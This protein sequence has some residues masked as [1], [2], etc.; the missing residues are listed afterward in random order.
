MLR[1]V[2]LVLFTLPLAGC[3]YL[4]AAKGQLELTR[5]REPI[6]DILQDEDTSPELAARLRLVQEA[7][8]FSIEVLG[9][10]DNDSYRTF[11]DIE[12]DY[13]VWNVFA[14]PEFSMQPKT[15]CFPVAGCVGYR[16]YF[17]EAA[18]RRE[19]E[20]LKAKGFDVVVGGVAAYSTLGKLKDPVVS[21]MMRWDDLQLVA[22]L[23]HELAHQ[24]LYVKGDSGFNESFATAVEEFG[25]HQWL[26]ARGAERDIERYESSRLLRQD[27]ME[28]VADARADLQDLYTST[29]SADEMRLQKGVRLDALANNVVALLESEGRETKGWQAA[30]LN[31]ARLASMALYEGRVP[32]FRA[33]LERCD[34]QID[35][36]YEQARELAETL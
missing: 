19:A 5:K 32:E 15:W 33:I 1:I 25:V 20:R 2:L 24:V 35:C 12:R 14:A 34:Q 23:F 7:R 8:Q 13:V 9:L 11:A 6:T 30:D 28:L 3:Y 4:Q 18:A 22:V 27:L 16:G 29:L 31:N 21:S 36:F 10:P 26:N 17:E